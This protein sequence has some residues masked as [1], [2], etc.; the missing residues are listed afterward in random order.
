MR[1]ASVWYLPFCPP[2]VK[3]MAS[4]C[5]VSRIPQP[6]SYVLFVVYSAMTFA[7]WKDLPRVSV[8]RMM[9]QISSKAFTLVDYS[10][11]LLSSLV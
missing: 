7:F 8:S 2:F 9:P 10:T 4:V 1:V 5:C 11:F 6:V 3:V